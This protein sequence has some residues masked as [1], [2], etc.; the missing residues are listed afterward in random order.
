MS[1][2]SIAIDAIPKNPLRHPKFSLLDLDLLSKTILSFDQGSS[3][4][5]LFFKAF[6]AMLYREFRSFLI[7]LLV[8]VPERSNPCFQYFG[9]L[10]FGR[11]SW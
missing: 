4:G 11:L 9:D 1:N 10:F 5:D 6:H 8:G 3:V 2:L 7:A